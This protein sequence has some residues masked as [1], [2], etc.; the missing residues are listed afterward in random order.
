MRKKPSLESGRFHLRA[1]LGVLFCFAGLSLGWL[2]LAAGQPAQASKRAANEARTVG[3][4]NRTGMI[5][6]LSTVTATNSFVKAPAGAILASADAAASVESRA[7]GF[8]AAHGDLVG[9]NDSERQALS[10]GRAA[11]T[12]STLQLAKSETDSLGQTHVRFDQFYRGLRVFGAQLVVHMNNDGITAVNGNFIPNVSVSTVPALS[13][14]A[15]AENAVISLRKGAADGAWKTE[16]TELAIYPHGL[17]QGRPVRAVLAYSIELRSADTAEQ[18]WIDAN[19]A[20]SSFASR[21]IK[22][23]STGEFTLRITI[24]V[25]RTCFCSARKA[26]RRIR[27]RS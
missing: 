15:A 9:L 5:T 11:E 4:L 22:R 3:Q 24:R 23:R 16:K 12:G 21:G 17:A 6:Q 2:S 19:S 18:V 20:P 13:T 26:I 25:I 7:L 27:P 8:L 1:I 10:T 14:Q